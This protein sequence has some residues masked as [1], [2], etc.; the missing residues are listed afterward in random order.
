MADPQARR[1]LETQVAEYSGLLPVYRRL[2]AVLEA[3]LGEAAR[4]HAPLAIVQTRA[5]KVPSFAEK[6]LRKRGKYGMPA[7]QLTDLCGA[8]LIAR[9]GAEVREVSRFLEEHLV[10]GADRLFEA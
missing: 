4:R 10:V 1:W 2:A 5:K 9:T 3:V 8:R 6:S 7:H